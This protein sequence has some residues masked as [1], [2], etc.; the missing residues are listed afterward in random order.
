MSNFKSS[1]SDNVYIEIGKRIAAARVASGMTQAELAEAISLSRTSVTNIEVGRQ[2]ILVHMLLEIAALLR[3]EV[4]KLLPQTVSEPD[5]LA[6]V[7]SLE[8]LNNVER[9]F[10]EK[11]LM[12]G[13]GEEIR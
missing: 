6:D 7:K 13:N 4:S 10:I 2:K 8:K 11:A 9:A 3:V 5:D 1:H 12:S